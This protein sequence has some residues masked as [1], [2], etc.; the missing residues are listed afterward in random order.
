MTP[1]SE[2]SR[3]SDVLLG[4]HEG[5]LD[6]LEKWVTSIDGKLDQLIAAANMGRGAWWAFVKLGGLILMGLAALGW[7]YDHALRGKL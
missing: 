7:I 3:S 5:R 2:S 6:S 1:S 4:E